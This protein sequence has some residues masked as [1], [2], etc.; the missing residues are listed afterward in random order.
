MNPFLWVLIAILAIDALR[1]YLGLS[2]LTQLGQ[3][4]DALFMHWVML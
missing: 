2:S 3:F 1:E 4:I